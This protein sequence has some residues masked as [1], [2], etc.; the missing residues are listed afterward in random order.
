MKIAKYLITAISLVSLSVFANGTKDKL[1]SKKSY[2]VDTKKSSIVWTGKKVTGQ[3]TGTLKIKSGTLKYDGS[4]LTGGEFVIDMTSINTTDLSGEWKAK[5]DGH[6]KNDD[7]FATDKH[8]TAKLVIKDAQFGKGGHWDVNGDLTIK[9]ITK[10]IMFKA[11]VNKKGTMVMAS[12]D[13]KFNRLDYGVKYKSG[14]FFKDLGD[15]MIYDDV[16]LKVNLTAK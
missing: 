2:S 7:F 4:N 9:G 15:K 13:I 12:A 6:L 11:N 14:K 16:E 1:P 10:P 5:L 3:H 8:K